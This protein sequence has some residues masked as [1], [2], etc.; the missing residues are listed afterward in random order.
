VVKED[1]AVMLRQSALEASNLLVDTLKDGLGENL[2]SV[3]LVG[4]CLTADFI[5]KKSDINSVIVLKEIDRESLG[6]LSSMAKSLTKRRIS[7]PLT[8]TGPYIGRSLDVFGMEFLNFINV[9]KTVFGEDPF[10]GLEIKAVDVRLQ[11]ER[12]LKAMLIRLRQ[13][14][15]ASRGNR[16]IVGDILVSTVKGFGPI[17]NA[18]LWLRGV[19]QEVLLNDIFTAAGGEFDFT[20]DILVTINGMRRGRFGMNSDETEEAFGAVY[21]IADQLAGLID[22]LETSR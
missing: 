4:S 1:K 21:A 14:Y 16:R 11:C 17:L 13:G 18:M 5:E 22:T 12:E 10:V 8:M 2:L 9:H 3:S 6:L 19:G 15:L 7:S 20:A